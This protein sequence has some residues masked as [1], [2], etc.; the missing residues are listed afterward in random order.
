[1]IYYYYYC[2]DHLLDAYHVTGTSQAL[3]I[4]KWSRQKVMECTISLDLSDNK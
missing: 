1:M 2:H 4:Q 3:R